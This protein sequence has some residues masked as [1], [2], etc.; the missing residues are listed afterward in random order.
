MASAPVHQYIDERHQLGFPTTACG[1]MPYLTAMSA[2]WFEPINHRFFPQC[3]SYTSH[4]EPSC[5][6]RTLIPNSLNLSLS[7][8]SP[9]Y[10]H[11]LSLCSSLSLSLH[12]SLSSPLDVSPAHTL[13]LQHSLSLNASIYL[14]LPLSLSWVLLSSIPYLTSISKLDLFITR[15]FITVS[16]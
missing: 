15:K 4:S 6:R 9:T 2:P 1:R 3:I 14:S 7:R 5:R 12:H 10:R 13:S 16:P 8:P 11:S